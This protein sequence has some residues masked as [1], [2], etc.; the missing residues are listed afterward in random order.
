MFTI[1][2]K[3]VVCNETI[4]ET[5]FSVTRNRKFHE[6]QSSRIGGWTLAKIKAKYPEA[7]IRYEKDQVV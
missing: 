6:M 7:K 3:N 1:T 4:T 5:F 2:V